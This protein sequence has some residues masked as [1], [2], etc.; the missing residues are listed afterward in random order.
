MHFKY[1]FLNFYALRI[2]RKGKL[3]SE[4]NKILK[5]FEYSAK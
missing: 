1:F 2:L 3:N 4:D 5:E